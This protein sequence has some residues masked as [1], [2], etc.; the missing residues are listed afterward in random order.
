MHS[1][2]I[3][4]ALSAALLP[5][6]FLSATRESELQKM[7]IHQVLFLSDHC[8][9]TASWLAGLH[10]LQKAYSI[11]ITHRQTISSYVAASFDIIIIEAEIS[12]MSEVLGTCLRLR[13]FTNTPILVVSSIEDEEYA[14]EVYEVGANEYI[15]KPVSIE[16][17]HAKLEAWRRWIVPAKKQV[18]LP[19]QDV[20]K[21]I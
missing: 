4:A 13:A 6:T 16:I 3:S 2:P 1:K 11:T 8:D 10:R 19:A 15:V 18:L 7:N 14:L 12:T 20:V 5:S 17:V 21:V 9:A